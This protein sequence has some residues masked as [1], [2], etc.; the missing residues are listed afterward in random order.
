MID[1]AI[2]DQ[3][4][5]L[6]GSPWLFTLGEQIITLPVWLGRLGLFAHAE[7]SPH[8]R[9]AMIEHSDFM[10]QRVL[11]SVLDNDV[12]PLVNDQDPDFASQHDQC[13]IAV[14]ACRSA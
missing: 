14:C 8:A 1:T 9:A 7:V 10:L 4:R 11:S 6:R 2:I 3:V 12:H 5:R 13:Y